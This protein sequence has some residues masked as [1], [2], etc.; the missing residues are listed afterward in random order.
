MSVPTVIPPAREILF[1]QGAN[2]P[3]EPFAA[4]NPGRP[5]EAMHY[6]R[7][8]RRFQAGFPFKF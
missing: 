6:Q 4:P 3:D 1:L 8:G 7:F 2:L 5:P